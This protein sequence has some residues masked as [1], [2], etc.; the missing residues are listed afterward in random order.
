MYIYI[1]MSCYRKY[2]HI[3]YIFPSSSLQCLQR[4]DLWDELSPM[5]TKSLPSLW[6]PLALSTKAPGCPGKK[7]RGDLG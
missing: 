5:C 7:G 1:P 3:L 4:T 6:H 2:K